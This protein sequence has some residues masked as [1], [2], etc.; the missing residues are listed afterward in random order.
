MRERAATPDGFIDLALTNPSNAAILERLEELGTRDTWL[1]AGCLF[2]T[3]WNVL[4]GQPP[5]VHIN[6]Y[7]IFYFDGDDL[8]FEAED[9]VIRRAVQ[10]F[11]DIDAKVE[12]RNQARV[13]L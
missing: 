5:A 12:V 10:L 4:S 13:H 9:R 1:V 3:V 8:S 6:D 7:D 11:R 2:Q